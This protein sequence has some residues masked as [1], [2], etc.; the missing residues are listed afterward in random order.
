VVS[1]T[2][3]KFAARSSLQFKWSK[4]RSARDSPYLVGQHDWFI[5][6][7]LKQNFHRFP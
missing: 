4:A 6:Q 3:R 2:Y 7:E 5:L 1:G